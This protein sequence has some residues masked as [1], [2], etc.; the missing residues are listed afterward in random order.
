VQLQVRWGKSAAAQIFDEHGLDDGLSR[1]GRKIHQGDT[2][3]KQCWFRHGERGVGIGS[4]GEIGK[5]GRI[6]SRWWR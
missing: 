1:P 2:L 3:T 4:A 5:V 6:G